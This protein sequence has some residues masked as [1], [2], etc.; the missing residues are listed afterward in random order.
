MEEPSYGCAAGWQSKR[1]GCVSSP[2]TISVVPESMVNTDQ[3]TGSMVAV[4]PFG[5]RKP[6]LLPTAKV[7]FH[8]SSL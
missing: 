1:E 4:K 5:S 6:L 7:P 2:A 8:I 3:L